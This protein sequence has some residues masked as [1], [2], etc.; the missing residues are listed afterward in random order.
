[1]CLQQRGE[2]YTNAFNHSQRELR[3]KDISL[4]RHMPDGDEAPTCK[5]VYWTSAARRMGL[6]CRLNADATIKYHVNAYTPTEW[7]DDTIAFIIGTVPTEMTRL[8]KHRVPIPKWVLDLR[9]YEERQDHAGPLE[10][11]RASVCVVCS[12]ATELEFDTTPSSER[13]S[14]IYGCQLCG[15]LWHMAC[16]RSYAVRSGVNALE[17]TSGAFTCAACQKR[18][19]LPL[20]DAA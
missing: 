3:D 4:L 19:S 13:G 20:H 8:K 6:P 12:T 11:D 15:L 2:T 7:P 16:A 10:P 18:T 14:L 1:M 17:V 5:L 9:A